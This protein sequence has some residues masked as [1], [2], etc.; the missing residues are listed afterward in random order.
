MLTVSA[1]NA[2]HSLCPLDIYV[3]KTVSIE[4]VLTE[5]S[6]TRLLVQMYVI[7]PSPRGALNYNPAS[8]SILYN[9]HPELL[10]Y[11]SFSSSRQPNLPNPN[12]L[13][14]HIH[15]SVCIFVLSLFPCCPSQVRSL[16]EG[17]QGQ[18]LILAYSVNLSEGE[19]EAGG[20]TEMATSRP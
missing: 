15:T 1:E 10:G 17:V 11:C 18:A 9:N 2:H 13:H 16:E 5:I 7:A 12:L 20:E 14:M 8:C 3:L 19:E 6:D 4:T